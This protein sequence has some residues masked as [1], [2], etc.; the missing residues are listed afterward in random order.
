[1]GGIDIWTKNLPANG[2][3]MEQTLAPN[4]P[5][6]SKFIAPNGMTKVVKASATEKRNRRS[7]DSRVSKTIAIQTIMMLKMTIKKKKML[8]RVDISCVRVTITMQEKVS[9]ITRLTPRY[10]IIRSFHRT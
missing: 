4:N 10:S 7:R 8:V 5:T 2:T 6:M 3:D 9:T 1:M